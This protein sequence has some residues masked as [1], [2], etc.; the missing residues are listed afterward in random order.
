MTVFQ[1]SVAPSCGHPFYASQEAFLSYLQADSWTCHTCGEE[2]DVWAS[3]R[4]CF[5]GV[6]AVFT[7]LNP[8][9][10]FTAHAQIRLFRGELTWIDLADYGAAPEAVIRG[11]NFTQVNFTQ[12]DAS[13]F[14]R[15]F[16][17]PAM[18][19]GNESR[20]AKLPHRMGI[21]PAPMGDEPPEFADFSLYVQFADSEAALHRRL[22]LEGVYAHGDGD[23][24]RAVIDAHTAADSLL[25]EVLYERIGHVVEG[26]PRLSF[27]DKVRVL[28]TLRANAGLPTLP[29]VLVS[30]LQQLNSYR[31]KVA[32]PPGG[33]ELDQ[34]TSAD[35]IAA[36]LFLVELLESP[37]AAGGEAAA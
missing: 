22:L 26:T 7:L 36:A 12:N 3:V 25:G 37:N 18:V 29:R 14:S 30:R 4:A 5:V 32:H 10:G 34:G 23:Y 19:F 15:G 13:D 31:N 28:T 35:L 17:L 6:G 16:L 24:R 8:L 2:L 27:M 11:V 20:V 1:G 21:F 9:R 33:T